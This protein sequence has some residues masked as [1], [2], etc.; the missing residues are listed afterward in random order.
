MKTD[1]RGR[2]QDRDAIPPS[3]RGG[4]GPASP[5]PK[6]NPLADPR[7]WW[8]RRGPLNDAERDELR[9]WKFHPRVEYERAEWVR[10]HAP[11]LFNEVAREM[12]GTLDAYLAERALAVTAGRPMPELSHAEMLAAAERVRGYD[13]SDRKRVYDDG[14]REFRRQLAAGEWPYRVWREWFEAAEEA[15]QRASAVAR[16]RAILGLRGGGVSGGF[17]N[18]VSDLITEIR[19]ATGGIRVAPDEYV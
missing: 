4:G 14:R 6:D 15:S 13:R 1:Y 18:G 12:A 5:P 10:E 16:A 8:H 3:L 17:S 9:A 19:Q 2:G 7:H 11:D